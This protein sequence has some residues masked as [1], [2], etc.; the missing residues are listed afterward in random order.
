MTDPTLPA[1]LHHASTRSKVMLRGGVVVTLKGIRNRNG[2]F[3][4]QARIVCPDGRERTVP[5]ASIV[6]L[7][8]EV[9]P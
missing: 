5:T 1:L 9:T 7:F 4:G 2:R 8:P 6:H 3:T